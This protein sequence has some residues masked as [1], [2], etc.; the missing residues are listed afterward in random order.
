MSLLSPSIIQGVNLFQGLDTKALT[1]ILD[2]AHQQTVARQAFYFHKDEPASILYVLV[3]GRVKLIQTT[4]EGHQVVLRIAVPGKMFGGIAAFS[5]TVYP[6]SAQAMTNSKSLCW[7]GETMAHLLKQYPSIALNALNHL[8][9]QLQEVQDRYR[10]LATEQVEQRIARALVRLVRQS[11]RKTK[12]GIYIDMPLSRQDLA[13]M[14][15]TTLFTVSRILSSWEHQS[16]VK[17]G[18]QKIT[19]TA[20]HALISLAE[21][22]PKISDHNTPP[23]S[24]PTSGL[25]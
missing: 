21:D 6:A 24:Q 3:Q 5:N 12:E 18:R 10:E 23:Q 16:L 11:G 20:P 1:S 19:I 25:S 9:T 8:A 4:P 22:L 15:G 14:T 2:K 13:E 7:N 17:T